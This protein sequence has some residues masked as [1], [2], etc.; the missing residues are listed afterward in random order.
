[1]SRFE[2]TARTD[3]CS[4]H[5]LEKTVKVKNFSRVFGNYK[6]LKPKEEEGFHFRQRIENTP[7]DIT[8]LSYS[9]IEN[10]V[11]EAKILG[12]YPTGGSSESTDYF[13]S[14][15]IAHCVINWHKKESG[16][17]NHV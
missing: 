8:L 16:E 15:F 11:Y 1:M 10:C 2:V 9:P 3:Y 12:S 14:N 17:V 13:E 6:I 5:D 7:L 4:I